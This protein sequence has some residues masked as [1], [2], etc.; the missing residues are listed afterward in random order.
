MRKIEK[1]VTTN[2][3]E[4]QRNTAREKHKETI[5]QRRQLENMAIV[6]PSL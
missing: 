6:N 2:I 1:Y 5:R 3:N 4:T